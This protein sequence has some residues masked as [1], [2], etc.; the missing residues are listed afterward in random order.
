MLNHINNWIHANIN[1]NI[2]LSP[3]PSLNL[4]PSFHYTILSLTNASDEGQLP[5]VK[6]TNS[7][8]SLIYA[9]LGKTNNLSLYH[10]LPVTQML[11][12]KH[13]MLTE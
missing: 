2:T 11:I 7:E 6:H 12:H 5:D 9:G 1:L 3:N 13:W 10:L 4:N 8:E